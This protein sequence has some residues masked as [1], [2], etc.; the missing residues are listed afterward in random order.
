MNLHEYQGKS[1]LKSFGVAIQEGIV[2]NTPEE[3]VEAA[4]EISCFVNS[5]C[6]SG[7]KTEMYNPLDLPNKVRYFWLLNLRFF[8]E[9]SRKFSEIFRFRVKIKI[10][11][12][13]WN[14]NRN[15]E[16]RN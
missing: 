9:V 10:N 13:F 1:L 5:F 4:K 7:G 6:C 2:A 14:W 8:T 16:H 12:L 15:C 3:A 11:L